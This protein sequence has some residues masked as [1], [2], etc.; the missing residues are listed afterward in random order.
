MIALMWGIGTGAAL[1][2]AIYLGAMLGMG[3]QVRKFHVQHWRE[4]CKRQG[5]TACHRIRWPWRI[6]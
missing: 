6:Q 3:H 2:L 4:I 5:G 1:T